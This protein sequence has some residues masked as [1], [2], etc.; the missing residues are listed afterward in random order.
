MPTPE[1]A[2]T[3]I[4]DTVTELDLPWE[5]RDRVVTV[6]LPGTRKLRTE[7]SLAV[8]E[9]AVEIRAFVARQP[10]ENH[11]R[12]YRWLLEH[13]LKTYGVAFSV[14][15][16]GDIHLTGRVALE[17]I[18]P[19]EVDRLLGSVAGTADDSFNIILELGFANSIRRE[20]QWRLAR[21]ESTANLA[22]FR[23]LGP[24]EDK[25][26]VEDLI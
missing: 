26:P 22:A 8:G 2:L 10:D 5:L 25:S 16:H 6:T 23:H 7:C 3:V 9:Y 4:V 12:V 17:S 14:D 18:T 21:G 19:E 1:D 11:E 15:H 13:N 24:P 20:W